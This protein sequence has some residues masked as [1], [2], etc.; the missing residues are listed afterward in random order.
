MRVSNNTL[1]VSSKTV[2][3]LMLLLFG[4]AAS[5]VVN[6]LT[7][8]ASSTETVDSRSDIYSEVGKHLAKN[9]GFIFGTPGKGYEATSFLELNDYYDDKG[10]IV[11]YYDLWKHGRMSTESGILTLTLQGGLVNAF[12]ITIIFFVT[13]NYACRKSHNRYCLYVALLL[14]IKYMFMYVDGALTY[15]FQSLIMW[16]MFAICL[17]HQYLNLT[18]EQIESYF[19]SII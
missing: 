3:V 17:S 12:L 10:N 16:I 1:K 18:D 7:D 4:L 5:G 6:V 15:F 14:S 8:F 13:I 9:N 2:L 11:S 19:K